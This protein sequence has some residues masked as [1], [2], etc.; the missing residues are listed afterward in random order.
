MTRLHPRIDVPCDG[1][2][3][4]CQGDLIRLENGDRAEDYK[5]QPHPFVS[6]A[7]MLAHQASG[8][9][10]Y[11]NSSGCGIHNN[12]PSLCRSADCRG[13]A[14]RFNFDAAIQL[15]AMRIIDIRVWDRGRMLLER[16]M[17]SK[18]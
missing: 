11:L 6:G 16:G 13:I 18:T 4:C 14:R 5:V 1:C 8:D 15:H 3:L 10:V 17:Q 9:C 2:T 12:A 7:L